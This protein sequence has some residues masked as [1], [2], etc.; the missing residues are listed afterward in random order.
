M[1]NHSLTD[2]RYLPD[3][4]T[5]EDMNKVFGFLYEDSRYY[6]PEA[7][8][9]YTRDPSEKGLDI[10]GYNYMFDAR[11]LYGEGQPPESGLG[12]LYGQD[13]QEVKIIF[14]RDMIYSMDLNPYIKELAAKYGKAEKQTYLPADVL[15]LTGENDKVRVKIVFNSISGTIS[16]TGLDPRAQAMDFYVLVSLR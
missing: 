2:V 5:L 10:A 13:S 4:F 8:F 12:V 16:P 15:M 14:D 1:R 3:N 6:P 11:S 9:Q 7:Y